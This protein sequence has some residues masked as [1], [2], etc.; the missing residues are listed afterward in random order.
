MAFVFLSETCESARIRFPIGTFYGK[1]RDLISD[2]ITRLTLT[3]GEE[4]DLVRPEWGL[5]VL[6]QE[7]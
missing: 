1:A 4:C 3:S 5:M 6:V 7:L 2:Q